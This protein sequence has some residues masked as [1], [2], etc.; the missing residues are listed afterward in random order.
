MR[1]IPN[2]TSLSWL[3][4]SSNTS[5]TAISQTKFNLSLFSILVCVFGNAFDND[6]D[7]NS[8]IGFKIETFQIFIKL[9]WYHSRS[10]WYNFRGFV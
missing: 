6:I 8:N 1:K 10:S 3:Q 7:I 9:S 2:R 4:K 5:G